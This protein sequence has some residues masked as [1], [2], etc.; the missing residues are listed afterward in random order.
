MSRDATLAQ[1]NPFA[2]VILAQLE[3]A[4]TRDGHERLARKAH[5]V[6]I[7]YRYG[8]SREDIC[9]V[10]RLID[11]MTA[12]SNCCYGLTGCWR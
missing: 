10:F 5:V 7:M 8:Y 3:A 12:T 11:W 6:R 2:L 4:A 1:H 9:Q